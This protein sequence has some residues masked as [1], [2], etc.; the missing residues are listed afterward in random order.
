MDDDRLLVP[1]QKL[2]LF[3]S[4]DLG[5]FAMRVVADGAVNFTKRSTGSLGSRID[6]DM[7]GRSIFAKQTS[8]LVCHLP[9]HLDAIF[10]EFEIDRI[11]EKIIRR[12]A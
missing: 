8:L 2:G 3:A 9:D 5:P 11:N 4:V 1:E 7:A 6:H 10:E 12:A